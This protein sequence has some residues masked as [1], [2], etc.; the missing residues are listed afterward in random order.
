MVARLIRPFYARLDVQTGKAEVA[1]SRAAGSI[2]VARDNRPIVEERREPSLSAPLNSDGGSI[3]VQRDDRPL[4][5]ERREPSLSPRPSAD[6]S[7]I[8]VQ[9][10]DKTIVEARR[11]PS[12][13][14]PLN[15]EGG[16][17]KVQRNEKT[18]VED[19]REPSLS[20]LKSS[21]NEPI[22]AVRDSKVGTDE[23]ADAPLPQAGTEEYARAPLPPHTNPSDNGSISIQRDDEAVTEEPSEP[24]L[25][26]SPTSSEDGAAEVLRNAKIVIE[27]LEREPRHAYR[28]PRSRRD[29]DDE[30]ISTGTIIRIAVAVIVLGLGFTALLPSVLTRDPV[31]ST[32]TLTTSSPP[33]QAAPAQTEQAGATQPV[34][35]PPAQLPEA[36]PL[37]PAPDDVASVAKTTPALRGS[38]TPAAQGEDRA[39]TQVPV[40]N[41]GGL[42]LTAAE[43][44]AVTRGLQELEKQ[45]A[46]NPPPRSRAPTRPQLTDEEKA[47]VERGLRELE[48][49]AGQAKP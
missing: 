39:T 25:S 15:S 16:S 40:V 8:K 28:P 37:P 34:L 38:S 33:A 48:K 4:I 31:Q 49:T 7:S 5:E 27:E 26:P 10:D 47:A 29:P 6:R 30:H 1:P 23:Y 24:P 21:N 35:P 44:A 20:S 14:A 2:K 13:S 36:A 22:Q 9:R 43:K 46:V 18:I 3:R 42:A 11:E 45:A 19:R 17:I 32:V 41:T 12:L